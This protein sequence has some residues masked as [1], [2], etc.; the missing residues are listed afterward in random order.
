MGREGAGVRWWRKKGGGTGEAG[1]GAGLSPLQQE[2]PKGIQMTCL[3]S[4]REA[5]CW[6]ENP[7]SPHTHPTDSG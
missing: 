5:K 3:S 6:P 2:L 7:A 1:P 4:T